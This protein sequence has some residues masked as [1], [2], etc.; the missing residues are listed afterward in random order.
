[1]ATMYLQGASHTPCTDIVILLY[2]VHPCDI[3]ILVLREK[4]TK[5]TLEKLD[6]WLNEHFLER[7]GQRCL[8]DSIHVGLTSILLFFEPLFNLGLAVM[9]SPSNETIISP[10]SCT[11]QRFH[12]AGSLMPLQR[13]IPRSFWGRDSRSALGKWTVHHSESTPFQRCSLP[14]SLV[15]VH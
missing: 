2:L 3:I 12:F 5:F 6:F 4:P 9:V 10:S 8:C 7:L 1:M 11:Q 15:H 13:S 14:S